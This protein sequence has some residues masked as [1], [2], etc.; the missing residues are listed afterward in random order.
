MAKG[1]PQCSFINTL[2]PDATPV[3]NTN[4]TDKDTDSMDWD[5]STAPSSSDDPMPDASEGL[6]P[7]PMEFKTH[8]EVEGISM[9]NEVPMARDIDK[10]YR[11]HVRCRHLLFNKLRAMAQRGEVPSRL[12]TC[13]TPMCA[14]CQ[15]GKATK[16]AWQTKK[17]NRRPICNATKPGECVSIDQIESSTMGLV[18]QLKGQLTHG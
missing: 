16:K 1:V 4:S 17:K 6:P 18:A 14:A 15:F 9:E 13:A 10:I 12:A 8:P 2:D 5:A 7:K 11:L 3:T